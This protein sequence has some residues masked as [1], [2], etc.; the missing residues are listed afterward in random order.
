M[1]LPQHRGQ[2]FKRVK[3]SGGNLDQDDIVA[4]GPEKVLFNREIG[5]IVG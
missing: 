1:Q 2:G 4:E 5:D 3:D